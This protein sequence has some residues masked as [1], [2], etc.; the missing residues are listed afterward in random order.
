MEEKPELRLPVQ[1]E[2]KQGL[3]AC[4]APV[5]RDRYTFQVYGSSDS[6]F[7]VTVNTDQSISV[8]I[9]ARTGK[10]VNKLDNQTGIFE[11]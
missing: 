4:I 3:Q 1:A 7:N 5:G 8:N 6:G 11:E 9:Y 2:Y 10:S